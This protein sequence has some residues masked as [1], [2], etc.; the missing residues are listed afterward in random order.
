MEYQKITNLLDTTPDNVP[1]FITRKQIEVHDQSGGSYDTNKQ[2]KFK[3][4][5]PRSDLYDYSDA[6]IIVEGDITVETEDDRAI[7]GYNRNLILKNNAPFTSY[8]SKIN[9]VLIGNAE[10]LDILMSMY[11]LIEYSKNYSKTSGTLWNYTKDIPACPITNFE[12][13]E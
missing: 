3:I 7:D 8:I 13:F 12:S 11:N 2:I 6:Y 1:R 5:M 10:D 4:S 9:N